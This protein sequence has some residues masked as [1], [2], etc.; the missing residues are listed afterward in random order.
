MTKRYVFF[1][2]PSYAL[3]CLEALMGEAGIEVGLVVSQ[4]DKPQGRKQ[5]LTPT[6]VKKRALEAGLP[7]L[8][9]ENI[10]AP[11]AIAALRRVGA[12]GAVVIAYGQKLGKEILALFGESIFNLHASLLPAYRGASPIQAALLAGE[13]ET[14]VSAMLVRSGMDSGEILAQKRRV[15]E[16]EDDGLTLADKLARDSAALMIEVLR[17]Y[18]GFLKKKQVQD[19]DQVSYTRKIT[20]ADAFLDFHQSARELYNQ[21]RALGTWPGAQFTYEG[22]TYKVHQAQALPSK[23]AA[24][25]GTLLALGPE[26]IDIACGQGVFRILLLQEAGKRPL[27]ARDFLNGHSWQLGACLCA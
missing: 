24:P 26:G 4:P 17:D 16:P 10:N 1:G 5:V 7:L 15:I 21:V 22:K 23:G 6:P 8:C 9:P 25:A 18:E 3:P 20:R 14:G 27:S 19:P 13:T 2:S 11:E 12:D